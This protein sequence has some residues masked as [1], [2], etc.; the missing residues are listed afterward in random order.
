MKAQ[1]KQYIAIDQY[2]HTY[3]GLTH[4]RKDLIEKIG[5]QHASKMFIDKADGSVV[6][7][8]YVIGNLWLRLYEIKPVE[9]PA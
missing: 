1:K 8:G 2:G 3:R 6:C 5:C 4:P 7:V 9:I